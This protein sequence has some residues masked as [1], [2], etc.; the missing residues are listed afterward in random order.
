M[1]FTL[2]VKQTTDKQYNPYGEF[3]LQLF[4]HSDEFLSLDID[5]HKK[6]FQVTAVHHI[7]DGNPKSEVYAFETSPPWQYSGK[8]NIGFNFLL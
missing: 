1:K 3:E 8:Q 2:F 6:Y 4:P 7:L 5:G